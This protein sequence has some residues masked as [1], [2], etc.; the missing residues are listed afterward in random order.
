MT[1]KK[2]R[3][4]KSLKKPLYI[5]CIVAIVGIIFLVLNIFVFNNSHFFSIKSVNEGAKKYKTKSCL[6]FYPN[7]KDGK[8]VVKDLCDKAE[9]ETIFD[10]A[11]IPYGDYYLVEYGNNVHYFIDHNNKPLIIDSINQDCKEILSD[12]LKYDMKKAE[13]DEAYTIDFIEKTKPENI[14]TDELTFD[15]VGDYLQ[16]YYPE[17][18]FTSNIPLKYS[19]IIANINLGYKDVEYVKPKYISNKRKTVA[20]TF[21]D[22][23]SLKIS[24]QIIDTFYQ[25]D[26]VATY[27]VLGNRLGK[28]T[29]G[30]IE[31]SIN[32]GNQYGS[33]TQSHP[34]LVLLN[35]KEVYEEIMRP[36]LDLKNGSNTGNSYDFEGLNYDVTVYRAPYGEH[37]SFV[38]KVAPFMSIE[39]D[40]DSKDWYY[41]NSEDIISGIY[42]FEEKNKDGLDGCIVLFHDTSQSTAD[43]IKLLV[44]ELIKKGYQFVTIDD[45]LSI[46]NVD[47]SKAYY[48][49]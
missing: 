23:P 29:I 5:I 46:N 13:I 16:V 28:D 3:L 1:V 43:A 17:Y 39:W 49:W 33:H 22:G 26:A 14:N 42:D 11:L 40:C 35:D 19:N 45:L 24:P 41:Q 12:Y 31:D 10:Y 47:R 36:A 4:R 25:N 9:G 7:T 34:Y 48:P 27:F 38:D 44:P 2:R 18:D 21:D 37:N 30:I 20:F 32:K 6:A 8:K 15:V